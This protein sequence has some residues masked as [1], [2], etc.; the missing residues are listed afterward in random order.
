MICLTGSPGKIYNSGVK[1]ISIA[2]HKGGVGK[3]AT[4][5][6]LGA[7]LASM[8]R[9]VLLVDADPQASLTQACGIGESEGRSLAEVLGGSS[10]GQLPIAAVIRELAAG[11]SL[12]PGDIALAACELGLTSRLG[13]ERVVA[14]ALAA[15]AGSYDV[16]LIDCAPSL[17]LL[18][19]AALCASAGV[20]IPTQ[21]QIADLRGLR[22][23]LTS[24]GTIQEEL[25]QVDI[26]GIL[27]TF[28]QPRL[29]HHRRALEFMREAGLPVLPVMIGRSVR[30]A[31][32]AGAGQSI[33]TYEP[34]HPQAHAYQELA[35]YID[36]WPRKKT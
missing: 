28:Y 16:C 1:V 26:V 15:V 36:L 25:H 30:L 4:A 33:V 7:A 21:P 31:D 20:L 34:D 6:A 23:F 14:R 17:G 12:A 5:H 8:G 22:L 11:L 32:A 9:R 10:P 24:V 19:V 29:V 35:E 18:T 27:V 2:N 3:T 13:R